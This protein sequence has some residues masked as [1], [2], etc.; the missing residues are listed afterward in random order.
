MPTAVLTDIDKAANY[1]MNGSVG[2]TLIEVHCRR[3]GSHLGHLLNVEKKLVHCING[4]AL[5]FEP[6]GA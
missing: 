6:A 3:C 4:V 5:K 2:R 1:S